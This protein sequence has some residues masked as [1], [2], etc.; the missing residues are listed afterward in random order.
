VGINTPSIAEILRNKAPSRGPASVDEGNSPNDADKSSNV[1]T[2]IHQ[3]DSRHNRVEI[4][5]ATGYKQLTSASNYSYR[6]FTSNFPFI[7]FGTGIWFTPKFGMQFNFLNSMAADA[8]PAQAGGLKSSVKH[9]SSFLGIEYRH[10]FSHLRMA[11]S[12]QYSAI[13]VDSK[14]TINNTSQQLVGT[15]HSG[16]GARIFARWPISLVY[17]HQIWAQVIPKQNVSEFSSSGTI[18]SGTGPE[19]SQLAFGFGGEIKLHR[20]HQLLWEST[21]GIDK[22]IYGESAVPADAVS[23]STVT[24]V[25]VQSTSIGFNLT[26]RWGK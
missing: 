16:V 13:Y 7:D 17:A 1:D 14:M 2:S 25:T 22:S 24:G 20:N 18:S 23:G 12:I 21:Y 8:S 9:E 10:F 3:D 19:S 5:I 11:K 26:Y 6:N 15:K 4:D